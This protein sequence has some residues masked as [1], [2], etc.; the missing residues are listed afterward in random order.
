MSERGPSFVVGGAFHV[1]ELLAA[2]KLGV[3]VAA[4]DGVLAL[5]VGRLVLQSEG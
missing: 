1:G 5:V 2:A 4:V 3:L